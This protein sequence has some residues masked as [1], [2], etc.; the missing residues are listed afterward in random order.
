M[1]TK[2]KETLGAVWAN[3]DRNYNWYFAGRLTLPGGQ[4]IRIE[5]RANPLHKSGDRL[6]DYVIYVDTSVYEL[7]E[8]DFENADCHNLIKAQHR[9]GKGKEHR[10]ARRVR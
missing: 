7:L 6:P 9:T 8:S 10:Q 1:N 2:R 3:Q 5:L 4:S